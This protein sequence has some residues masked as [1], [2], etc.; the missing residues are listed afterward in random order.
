MCLMAVIDTGR[1]ADTQTILD[2][3]IVSGLSSANINVNGFDVEGWID[4]MRHLFQQK[5]FD[6][7]GINETKLTNDMPTSNFDIDGYELFRADRKKVGKKPGGCALNISDNVNF[8]E[9]PGLI[10]QY[11]EG[12]CGVVTFPNKH[13]SIVV[14]IYRPPNEKTGL[15]KYF[16]I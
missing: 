11:I 2:P 9:K 5:P 3:P 10:P 6:I 8:D 13:N 14:N 16:I 7:I 1:D 15:I 12:I 4:E